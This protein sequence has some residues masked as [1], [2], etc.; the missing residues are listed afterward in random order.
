MNVSMIKLKWTGDE[1]KVLV[2]QNFTDAPFMVKVDALQDWIADLT[3]IYK[4]L[5]E[6]S[7]GL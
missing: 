7:D 3:S 6:K 5:L 2:D 1:G 4:D